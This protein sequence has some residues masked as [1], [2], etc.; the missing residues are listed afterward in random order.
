[1]PALAS[2]KTVGPTRMLPWSGS[3]RPAMQRSVVVLPQPLGPSRVKKVPG[4]RVKLA[5]SIPLP[6][7]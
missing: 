6:L 1:M 4:A 2:K 3:S 5:S 7:V